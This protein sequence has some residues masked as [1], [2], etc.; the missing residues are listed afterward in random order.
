MDE[1]STLPGAAFLAAALLRAAFLARAFLARGFLTRGLLAAALL[2][3]GFLRAALRSLA[4]LLPALLRGGFVLPLAAAGAAL[5]AAPRGRVDRGP[6]A[7]LGLLLRH[8]A[9]FVALLDVLG[10][11]LLLAGVTAFV[12]SRHTSTL[13]VGF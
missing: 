1:S 10:L 4:A 2:A 5:L 11:P 13:H 7:P 6:R 12:A 3:R 8:A 9:V